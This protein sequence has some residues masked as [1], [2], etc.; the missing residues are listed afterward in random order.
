M[1]ESLF[2]KIQVLR[3]ATLLKRDS[4]ST[5]YRTLPVAVSK[6]GNGKS[7]KEQI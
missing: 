1:L 7:S 5:F 4:N 2:N 6:W 3:P